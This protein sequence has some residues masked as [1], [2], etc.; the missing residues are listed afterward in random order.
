[1]V[2]LTDGEFVPSHKLYLFRE[3]EG[4]GEGGAF[5]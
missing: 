2:A 3:H 5:A 4:V 1:M